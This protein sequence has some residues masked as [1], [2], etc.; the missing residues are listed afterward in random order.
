MFDYIY[1]YIYSSNI[2]E[3]YDMFYDEF[4]GWEG[5]FKGL[6][7]IGNILFLGKYCRFLNIVR[8]N[9]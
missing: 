9:F 7:R 2:Y 8:I 4:C 3:I 5:E 1:I 6:I